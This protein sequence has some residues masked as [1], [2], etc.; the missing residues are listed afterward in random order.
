M[1][2]RSFEVR[3]SSFLNVEPVFCETVRFV[4]LETATKLPVRIY[5]FKSI[6]NEFEAGR[7]QLDL[8]IMNNDL[9]TGIPEVLKKSQVPIYPSLQAGWHARHKSH[10]FRLAN[11]VIS[12]FAQMLKIDPWMLGCFFEMEDNI[13]INNEADR[14]RLKKTADKLF[15]RIMEKYREHKINEKPYIVVK[16]DSGTYGMGLM[17]IEHPDEILT[18]NRKDRN[19]L[20]VGKN[21]QVIHRYLLQEGVPTIYECEGSV[22]EVVIYQ[23]ENNLVGGFY[24]T[25][26]GKTQRE[27][28]NAQGA[29]FKKM[30][31][32]LSKYGDCGPH[33]DVNVF[34]LYRY[35]ARIAAIAAHREMI[36]LEAQP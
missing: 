6:L 25:H 1:L 24:R 16:S 35:L 23:I 31:P 8:V 3:I 33:L 2:F 14:Q 20:H 21:A 34:D 26:T 28:L 18:L 13:D 32:H 5:C 4:E 17:T 9:T 12:E 11:E 10:H 36:H 19:K 29:V 27:N 15:N 30:C 22:S 7:E